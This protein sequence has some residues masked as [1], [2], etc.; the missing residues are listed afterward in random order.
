MQ[1]TCSTVVHTIKFIFEQESRI[2]GS[3]SGKKKRKSIVHQ[4]S[5]LDG[6]VVCKVETA[7]C[8]LSSLLD[9]LILKKDIA[10]RS[11]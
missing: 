7:L 9:I 10:S 8:L 2:G 4:T 5:T 11:V 1:I 6:D 3:A